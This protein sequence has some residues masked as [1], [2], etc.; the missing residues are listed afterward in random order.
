MELNNIYEL[1]QYFR[2]ENIFEMLNTDKIAVF[3]SFARN[4]PFNDIDLIIEDDTNTKALISFSEKLKSEVKTSFDIVI[5]KYA[6][7][8]ILLRAKKDIK[9][10]TRE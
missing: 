10:I 7:P 4:E 3:G 8:I 6:E 5:A 1:E 9:Y 2:K